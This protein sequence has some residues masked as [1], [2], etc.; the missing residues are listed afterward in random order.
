MKILVVGGGG[1]EHALAWKLAQSAHCT[2][3][4]AAPGNPGI[5]A[6]GECVDIAADDI[7]GLLKFAKAE[8]VG[9]TVVGP[10]QPLVDGIVDAFR[11]QGLRV[12][13]PGKEAAQAEGSKAWCKAVMM[14]SS[15]PTAE[16]QAFENAAD[17]L[18]YIDNHEEP[19]VV[20]ASGLAAGKGVFVCKNQDEARTAVRTIIDENAFGQAG[21]TVVVEERL[22]GEEASILALVDDTTIYSLE[23]SQDH[24]PAFDSDKG[25]NTGGMGAYSP[26]PVVTER[27]QKQIDREVLVPMVHGMKAAG[28]PYNGLLYAGIMVTAGGP[29]VL[30]FNCRFGDPEAQPLLMR[31]RSDL[32]EVLEATIDSR[33]EE[34]TLDW[35]PRPAVC[36][37]MAS[38]GYPGTYEKGKEIMGLEAASRLDDVVVFHAGTRAEDGKVVTNGG[39][40]LG[41]TALGNDIGEARDRAYEAVGAIH[42]HRAH[43]RT[44]IGV[45]GIR[46][47]ANA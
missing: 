36:V 12:F 47:L 22:S 15:V 37:V 11:A 41:V 2:R 44:D 1:R 31:L 24:K 4:Y 16:Y 20:K 8:A 5:A 46:R 14:H 42:F 19:L 38:G 39:R 32:V 23:S 3:L 10:E 25:P 18:R 34:I 7:A 45:K 13:G 21:S 26:A 29:K 17:A 28:A 9:L 35:D 43:W 40:V 30:E 27:I 6:V 33:L